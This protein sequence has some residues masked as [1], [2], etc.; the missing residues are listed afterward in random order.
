MENGHLTFEE[1]ERY[2]DDTDFS[3]DYMMFCEP[4][5]GHLDTCS[6]CRDR[7]DKLVLLSEL[8]ADANIWAA[9]NLVRQEEQIRH[10]IAQ[11]KK[12]HKTYSNATVGNILKEGYVTDKEK[13]IEELKETISKLEEE[14]EKKEAE[15]QQ[16]KFTTVANS[17]LPPSEVV[18][19]YKLRREIEE[20]KRKIEGERNLLEACESGLFDR[21]AEL[22]SFDREAL[23]RP[24]Y[25]KGGYFTSQDYYDKCEEFH[26]LLET[27]GEDIIRMPRNEYIFLKKEFFKNTYGISWLSEEEQYLPGSV[28]DVHVDKF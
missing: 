18:G 14:L 10:K 26:K 12:G 2:A 4:L 7:L 15:C 28:V 24:E 20:L 3:E 16:E 21:A 17:P 19:S 25:R 13:S 8:T 5:T 6:L 27:Q 11:L 23:L 1:L 22:P 9:L